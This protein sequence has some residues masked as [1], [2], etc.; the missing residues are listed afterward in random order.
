MTR[1]DRVIYRDSGAYCAHPCIARL[2]NGHLLVAFN[3][4]PPRRPFLHPPDEPR[5]LCLVVRSTDE[6]STWGE[7]RAAPGFLTTGVECPSI[8]QLD[9]GEVLLIQWRFAWFPLE[10]AHK[11]AGAGEE[12]VVAGSGLGEAAPIAS[13]ADWPLAKLPWAR[14][15]AG[16]F[17]SISTD[18][19]YTW[20]ETVQISTAPFRRGY[21]P[22]PPVQ[23]ADGAL[24]LA[25]ASHDARGV[26]YTL[27]STDRGR[28]WL[29]PT[30]VSDSAVLSEPTVARVGADRLVLL[31][32]HD[33]SGFLFQQMSTDAGQTWTRARQLPIW[34]YPAHL[35]SLSDGRLMAVY[36]YRRPPFG[37]R[38]C[39]SQD[40]GETWDM[41]HE[42]VIRDDLRNT[43]LGYP[44]AV[45]LSD[46]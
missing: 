15:D 29:P 25:V 35:L 31:A 20:D 26:L 45:E 18:D 21:S 46:G 17:C 5:T 3:E 44:T 30:V 2:R 40:G 1:T 34:G 27:R 7:P 4:S 9:S 6:G 41:R 23:I 22:R 24:L 37:I 33:A 28:T 8:T 42:L 16:L 38:A 39:F 14:T 13:E 32:R 43:N 11:R 12:F 10:T 36:G 19:G